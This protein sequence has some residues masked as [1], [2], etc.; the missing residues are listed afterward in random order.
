MTTKTAAK[1]STIRLTLSGNYSDVRNHKRFTVQHVEIVK[2][3]LLTIVTIGG[4]TVTKGNYV[5]NQYTEEELEKGKGPK[6]LPPIVFEELARL[7]DP[8]E[9]LAKI[10]GWI[11][12]NVNLDPYP[13]YEDDDATVGRIVARA[14]LGQEILDML[15]S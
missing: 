13:I 10:V 11:R 12:G 8:A 9:K 7:E 3:N 14:E 1:V 15:D 4:P 2:S 6:W 5:Y